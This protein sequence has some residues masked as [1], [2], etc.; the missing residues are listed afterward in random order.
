MTGRIARQLRHLRPQDASRAVQGLHRLGLLDPVLLRQ[1]ADVVPAQLATRPPSETLALLEGYAAAGNADDFMLPCLR[2]ALLPVGYPGSGSSGEAA[3][4]QEAQLERI[5]TWAVEQ[6]DGMEIVRLVMAFAHLQARESVLATLLACE[7][8][9][10]PVPGSCL[11][12][13]AAYA[14]ACLPDGAAWTE[15]AGRLARAEHELLEGWPPAAAL[16]AAASRWASRARPAGAA[17]DDVLLAV[18]AFPDHPARAEWEQHLRDRVR[19]CSTALLPGLLSQA[20]LLDLRRIAEVELMDRLATGAAAALPAAVLVA[21]ARALARPLP[22]RPAEQ[23]V[24][25]RRAVEHL[26]MQVEQ[27]TLTPGEEGISAKALVRV[28]QALRSV[29]ADPPPGL[30]RAMAESAATELTSTELLVALRQVP[31]ARALREAGAADHLAAAANRIS[32]TFKSTRQ[33]W[34]LDALCRSLELE[35]GEV[36]PP[37]GV[38]S[39]DE[40]EPHG[41][42]MPSA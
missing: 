32:G 31:S 3:P 37:A 25:A 18:S 36:E 28:L 40:A 41:K 22:G 42:S 21:A 38:A 30:L 16:A 15:A 9:P 20:A 10:E 2:R 39:D 27:L 12:A 24:R 13:A 26:A 11:L 29:R 7:A 34:E 33:T 35:L 5:S 19:E 6:L 23:A 8:S 17:P 1:V 14:A 4:R